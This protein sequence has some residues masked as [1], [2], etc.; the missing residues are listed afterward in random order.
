MPSFHKLIICGRVS[1]LAALRNV[2]LSRAFNDRLYE[3]QEC[4]MT[5]LSTLFEDQLKDIYYAEKQIVKA[6]P[7]MIKK[8]TSPKLKA[9][10]EKHL[11]ETEGQIERLDQVFELMDKPAKAKKCP[12]IDGILQEG[13]EILE[14]HE[15]GAGLDAAMAAAAQAVEHYEIARYGTLIA[16]GTELGLS[17]VCALIAETLKQEEA[18]DEALNKLAT[19]ELNAAANQDD[20]ERQEPTMKPKR[21]SAA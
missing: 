19:S 11:G 10:F 9:G 5:T 2:L 4:P 14:A 17:K 7:K 18:T 13:S 21:K 15:P 16:W 20:G 12:A 3:P 8:T 1:T 6:L